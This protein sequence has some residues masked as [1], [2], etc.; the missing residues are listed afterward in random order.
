MQVRKRTSLFYI[1]ASEIRNYIQV[2]E[3]WRRPLLEDL[4]ET[5]GKGMA[6]KRWLVTWFWGLLQLAEL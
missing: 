2:D 4:E 6:G 3:P 5:V 1:H